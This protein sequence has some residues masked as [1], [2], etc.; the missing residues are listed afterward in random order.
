MNK[1]LLSVAVL[2][3]SAAG[4]QAARDFQTCRPGVTLRLD[5]VIVLG[6]L[7]IDTKG[8]L[9]EMLKTI[10]K[11][12]EFSFNNT[13]GNSKVMYHI[14][15]IGKYKVGHPNK[16]LKKVTIPVSKDLEINVGDTIKVDSTTYFTV[17]SIRKTKKADR[18]DLVLIEH[19][20]LE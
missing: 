20:N 5:P 16:V 12:N 19:T 11:V 10:D 17:K 6:D 8:Q 13:F 15:K 4:L 18:K 9:T 1:L 3:S 7:V 2:I 14:T